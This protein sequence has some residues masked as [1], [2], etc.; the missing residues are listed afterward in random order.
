[1]AKTRMVTRTITRTEVDALCANKQTEKV[2]TVTL[3]VTGVYK[4]DGA[5]V[6]AVVKAL[7]DTYVFLSIKSATVS[8]KLYGITEDNF[9]RNAFEIAKNA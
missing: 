4:N 8:E 2:E 9:I 3:S 5:L 6:K 1:M 7:P